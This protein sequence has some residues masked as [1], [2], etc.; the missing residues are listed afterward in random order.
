MINRQ[1]IT[2]SEEETKNVSRYLIEEMIR[3]NNNL[4]TLNGDLGTGK[5]TLTKGIS[6]YLGIKERI[7]SPTFIVW[8]KYKIPNKKNKWED[9]VHADLYRIEKSEEI[10]HL[11]LK[12]E[13]ND[14]KNIVI[15]E[16]AEKMDEGSIFKNSINVDLKHGNKNNERIINIT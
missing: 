4:I 5:T 10:K 11:G 13:I 7:T 15:I 1:I 9:L 16:W 6:E 2:E 3:L 8:K 14:P 12:D